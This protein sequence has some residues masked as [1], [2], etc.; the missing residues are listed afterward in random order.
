MDPSSSA[1]PEQLVNPQEPL[2]N[3]LKQEIY[4]LEILN[5]HI[6][7]ENEAL[8]EQIKL[9]KVIHDNTIVHLG[10][11]YKKNRKL[12]RKNRNLNKIVIN[13]EY[14]LPMK[15]PR[16]VVTAKRNKKRKL[17]VLAHVSEQMQ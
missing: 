13:P 17:D 2:T 10:I 4:E 8:K 5:R 1:N 6:R 11:W 12:K 7:K 16:M 9:D 3:S 15:K 14:R